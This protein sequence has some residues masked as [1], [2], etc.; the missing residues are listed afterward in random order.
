MSKQSQRIFLERPMIE[1]LLQKAIDSYQPTGD[2]AL[3]RSVNALLLEEV[4]TMTDNFLTCLYSITHNMCFGEWNDFW[5]DMGIR[6]Y[7]A[8]NEFNYPEDEPLDDFDDEEEY[9][10]VSINTD[11]R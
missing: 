10:R 5:F 3:D 9:D 1:L 2:E 11:C 8:E 7:D 4:P 6:V